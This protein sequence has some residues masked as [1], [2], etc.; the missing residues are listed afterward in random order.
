MLRSDSNG[1]ISSHYLDEMLVHRAEAR[2]IR[3]Q[4]DS[5]F[6][7]YMKRETCGCDF[8]LWLRRYLEA[9]EAI[10]TLVREAQPA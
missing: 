8:C 2:R 10:D 3:F 7:G 1:G 9:T 4:H 5:N 6:Y